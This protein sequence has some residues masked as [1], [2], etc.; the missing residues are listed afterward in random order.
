MCNFK[1]CEE[2]PSWEVDLVDHSRSFL[3]SFRTVQ[4][5]GDHLDQIEAVEYLELVEGREVF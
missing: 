3:Q 2:S 5:C 4:L 1:G